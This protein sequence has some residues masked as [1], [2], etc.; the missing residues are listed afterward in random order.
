MGKSTAIWW[1]S[2]KED[3]RCRVLKLL[4]V[5]QRKAGPPPTDPAAGCGLFGREEEALQGVA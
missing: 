5:G 2:G 4:R 1:S 3:G